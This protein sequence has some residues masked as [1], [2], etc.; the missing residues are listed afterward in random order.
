MNVGK[1][2]SV[3][4]VFFSLCLIAYV[5]VEHYDSKWD[6]R[7]QSKEIATLKH[8]MGILNHAISIL[9]EEQR[10]E[11]WVAGVLSA[12]STAEPNEMREF[13]QVKMPQKGS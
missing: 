1:L 10:N 5:V 2:L 3:L 9:P 7:D 6:A 12:Y 8:Q 11:T 13:L 4:V